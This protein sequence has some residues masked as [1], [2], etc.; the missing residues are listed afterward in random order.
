MVR[1]TFRAAYAKY[2]LSQHLLKKYNKLHNRNETALPPPHRHDL[3]GHDKVTTDYSQA[4]CIVG[5][6]AA[7]LSAAVM[8]QF[9]GF[10]NITVLEASS[11]VGGRAYTHH[12]TAGVACNHNYYD[13]GAMRIP[14]IETQLRY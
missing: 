12:F 6:G 3:L 4:I 10:T 14:L 8:L 1:S 2:V 13:A 11:R 9:I 5:A 7:G